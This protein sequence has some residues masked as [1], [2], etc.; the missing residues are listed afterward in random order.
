MCPL[1]SM[2][3]SMEELDIHDDLGLKTFEGL[4]DF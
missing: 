3:A 4:A 2:A 1:P